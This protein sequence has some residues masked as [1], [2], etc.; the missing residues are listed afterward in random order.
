MLVIQADTYNRSRIKTVLVAVITKNLTLAAAPG[1]VLLPTK[2]S[3]LSLDSVIN[4]MQLL[5]IDRRLLTEFI[6]HLPVTLLAQ[7]DDGLR[8]VINL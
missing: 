2:Q 5:T 4:V 6:H 3:G 1:N 7:I 8:I